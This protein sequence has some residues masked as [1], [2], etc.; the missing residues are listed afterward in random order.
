MRFLAWIAGSLTLLPLSAQSTN[1]L[2]V[3]NVVLQQ[4]ESY[5]E[6]DVANQAS[7]PVHAWTMALTAKRNSTPSQVE[8]LLTSESCMRDA[9]GPLDA[10]QTRHCSVSLRSAS[11]GPVLEVVP[12]VTAVL[13]EDGAAE[14]DMAALDRQANDRAIRVRIRQ[15]WLDRFQEACAPG[16][17]PADQLKKLAAMVREPAG[18]PPGDLTADPNF[19]REKNRVEQ[20][21]DNAVQQTDAHNL[22]AGTTLRGLGS[23]LERRLKIAKEAAALFPPRKT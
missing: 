11:G 4:D 10:A 15:Y 5:V 8:F 16:V 23:E 13:F 3:R 14:G 12:R 21:V 20:Q 2:A 1:A 9:K 19:Q 6:F 18:P 7:K 17:A 22:D